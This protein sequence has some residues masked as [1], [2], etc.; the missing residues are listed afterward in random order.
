[1]KIRRK[2]CTLLLVLLCLAMT[3]CRTRTTGNDLDGQTVETGE[4]VSASSFLSGELPNDEDD[5]S[6]RKE[7]PRKNEEPGERT[8]ENPESPRKEYDENAPAEIVPGTNRMVYGEGEGDGTFEQG[9]TESE[10]VSKLNDAAAETATRKVPAEEAERLG[11]SEDA[12]EADSDMTYYTVLLAER[13]GSLFECQRQYV[14]WETPQEYVTIF[15][16]SQEHRLILNAGAYDVSA[17]LMEANLRVDD[18][19]V[20]RKNPGVIVKMVDSGVLGTGVISSGKARE[21]YTSL[22]AREGWASIDAVRNGRVLL[23]SEELLDAPHLQLAAMLA[24]GKT[25][26]PELMRETD[27]DRA[28]EAL[29]EEATGGIP[30]GIYYYHGEGGF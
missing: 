17:R 9:E 23:L 4:N 5:A 14:Y 12:Q 24:I 25:A 19:W 16:S 3:G 20:I 29:T 26:N 15:K 2:G 10:T 6:G 8:K 27:L 28:I 11:I 13:M 1:M 7:E 30:T 22:I 21:I 18:G